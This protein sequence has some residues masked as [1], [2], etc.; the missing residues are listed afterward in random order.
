MGFQLLELVNTHPS[1][2][3]NTGWDRVAYGPVAG[4]LSRRAGLSV[5][6]FTHWSYMCHDDVIK[7]KHFPRYWLFVRGIHRP[8]VNSPH[9][10]QWHG[11]CWCFL[12]SA[13]EKRLSKQSWGWWFETPS[14]PSW[15]HC[16]VLTFGWRKLLL[17]KISNVHMRLVDPSRIS[18]NTS[19]D[20]ILNM[21]PWC[22]TLVARM[23]DDSTLIHLFES[24]FPIPMQSYF[25]VN[26]KRSGVND[27][28]INGCY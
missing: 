20:F 7:W 2:S 22:T 11:K 25:W 27:M 26:I 13:P 5:I 23:Y 9:K 14:R 10:G 24:N 18:N 16:N 19:I 1:Q 3:T 17:S 8:P 12:W 15:R 28:L 4:C 21:G 6:G